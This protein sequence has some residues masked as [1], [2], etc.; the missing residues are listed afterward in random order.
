M[1]EAK[2]LIGDDEIVRNWENEEIAECMNFFWKNTC[3][4]I[5]HRIVKAEDGLEM[6]ID[7]PYQLS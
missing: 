7:A 1:K 5:R 6:E 4:V 2:I 3:Y